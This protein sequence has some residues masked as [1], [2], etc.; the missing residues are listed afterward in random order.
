VRS[1]GHRAGEAGQ[2][3]GESA[4]DQDQCGTDE[5]VEVDDRHRERVAALSDRCDG[6]V[7]F[8]VKAVPELGEGDGPAS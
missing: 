8:V 3:V 7:V 2:S 1:F 6:P 5:L 4:T